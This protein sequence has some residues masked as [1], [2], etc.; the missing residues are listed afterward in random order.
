MYQ[1]VG[2]F[3]VA[4]FGASYSLRNE[5]FC[6]SFMRVIAVSQMIE[7][8][9]ILLINPAFEGNRYVGIIYKIPGV[10]LSEN[11]SMLKFRRA[12]GPTF[13]SDSALP[14][15]VTHPAVR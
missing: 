6:Q 15:S 4:S 5:L 13:T 1:D 3:P 2:T 14:K 12:D 7:L 10:F 9:L 8:G 11:V